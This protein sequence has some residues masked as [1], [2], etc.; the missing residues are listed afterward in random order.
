MNLRL[1]LLKAV[2]AGSAIALFSAATLASAQTIP[3]T[4]GGLTLTPSVASPT[5]GQSVTITAKS[6]SVDIN[7]ANITWKAGGKTLQTGIG[8]TVITIKAP[9]LGKTLTVSIS[10]V[11]PDGTS[12]T[13]SLAVTSGTIDMIVEP[14]GYVPPMWSGKVQTAYQNSMKIVAVPHLANSAGVEYDPATLLYKWQQNGS[15]LESQ[16]GYGRQ[17]ITIP[18]GLIPR[19]YLMSVTASTRDGSAQSVG[20]VSVD[21]VQPY[22]IFY[23]NDPLYGPLYNNAIADTL[24]LGS[25][26]EADVLAVPYGFNMPASGLGD[27]VLSWLINGNEHPELAS[28]RSITLRT[29]DASAGSSNIE[30]ITTSGSSILQKSDVS[31]KV[32]FSASATS[33]PVSF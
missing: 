21:M 26:R 5:P 17:S 27:L 19:P 13:N 12:L 32:V 10:A 33:S 30:L 14:N 22:V 29:P 24:Y 28:S 18:G 2:V 15:A 20:Y 23:K 1:I 3:T 8:A 4:L 16:S 6:Y 31:F 9:A 11:M 25:G 7:S